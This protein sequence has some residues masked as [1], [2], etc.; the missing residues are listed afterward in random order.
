MAEPPKQE[1]KKQEQPDR[2]PYEELD[3]RYKNINGALAEERAG[4]RAA[5]EQHKQMQEL[6]Q[7][8]LAKQQQPHDQPE[9]QEDPLV[10]ELVNLK[11]GYQNL[12]QNQQQFQQRQ[13]EER[14]QLAVVHEIGNAER[15]FA[16]ATPDYFE[17]VQHLG[18]QRAAELSLLYADDDPLAQDFARKQGY[19]SPAHFR[20]DIMRREVINMSAVALQQGR[21]PAEL[22][23]GIAKQRGWAGKPAAPAPTLQPQ[24]METIRKGMEAPGSL[25]NGA[26]APSTNAEGYPSLEELADMYVSDPGKAEKTFKKMKEAG[27]LG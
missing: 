20:D 12:A 22:F 17:A 14:Q 15:K 3:R 27:L 11:Q 4:R 1:E 13:Q 10:R 19:Q 16:A 8:I 26:S 25:S 5:Q 6:F 2:L 23:Y 21:S 9:E 24:R 18:A 7:A